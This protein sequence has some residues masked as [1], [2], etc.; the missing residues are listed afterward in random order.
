M[1]ARLMR[2]YGPKYPFASW[3]QTLTPPACEWEI[4]EA[5]P[6]SF[7]LPENCRKDFDHL[8]I[9]FFDEADREHGWP[10]I[11]LPNGR[12]VERVMP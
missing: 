3:D 10:P 1:V 6:M 9:G 12:T 11:R 8:E 4:G 2:S 7:R 5:H